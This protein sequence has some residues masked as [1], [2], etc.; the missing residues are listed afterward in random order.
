MHTLAENETWNLVDVPKG[1][2]LVRCRW[3]YK[4]KYNADGS[5]NKYKARLLAMGYAQMHRIDYDETFAPVMKM[6]TVHVLPAVT[7]AKG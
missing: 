2:K 7:A 6:T 5:I 3:V 1:V 4:G